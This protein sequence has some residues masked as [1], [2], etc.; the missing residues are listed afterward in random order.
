MPHLHSLRQ[1]PALEAVQA[2]MPNET[3][4]AFMDDVLTATRPERVGVGHT[5]LGQVLPGYHIHG[6]GFRSRVLFNIGAK[7]TPPT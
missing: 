6:T 3:V 2:R 7:R 4:F 5:T 1:H